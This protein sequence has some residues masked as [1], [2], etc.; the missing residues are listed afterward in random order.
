MKNIEFT[1][2][3]TM[4][5][6][7]QS[8]HYSDEDMKRTVQIEQKDDGRY[9]YKE[10][11]IF[12]KEDQSYR[13]SDSFTIRYWEEE[14]VLNLLEKIGFKMEKDLSTCFLGNKRGK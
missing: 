7:F 14:T 13:Y 9:N 6:L 10:E 12:Q 8:T 11:V 4:H 3:Q 2:E 5:H 1:K